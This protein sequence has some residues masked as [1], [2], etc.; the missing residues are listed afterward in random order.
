MRQRA[1][2]VAAHVRNPYDAPPLVGPAG[3]EGFRSQYGTLMLRGLRNASSNWLGKVIMAAVVGFLV[4]SF[5]IWGIGDIFRGFGRSTFAK[6]GHT[7]VAIEQFR[8]LYNERIQQYGRQIGRPLTLDQARALGLDRQII[9]QLVSEIALDERARALRLSVS[10]AEIARR[11]TADPSFQGV[12]GQFDRQRF[13]QL[14]RQGGYTEARYVAE[15][16]RQMVR[17]QLAGSIIGD[18]ILPKAA[19]EAADRYHNEQRS[20][21]YV[22][23]DRAKA[24]EVAPPAPEVLAKYFEER[25]IL[26]RAPEYRKI[27]L[28]PLVPSEL[29]QTIEISDEDAKGA[30]EQRRARYGTPEQRHIQQLV[31]SNADDARA[32]ADRFAKGATFAQITADPAYA[33]KYIDLGLMAKT[34]L[35]DRA[36]ADA[37]FGLKVG[38]VSEPVQGRFGTVLVYVDKVEPEKTRSFEEVAAELKQDLAVE[39][40]RAKVS[41]LYNKIEDERSIG[42][43]LAETAEN[44]KLASRTIEVDRSGR[45]PSGTPVKDVPDS[46]RLL[47]AAFAA[48]PGVEND[49]LQVAGGYVWYDVS[50]LT[51]ARERTLDEVKEQVQARWHD[52]EVAS[53]LKN[54]TNEMLDKLKIGTALADV[55]KAEGLKVETKSGLKRASG[56]AAPLS[57]RAVETVFRTAKD[58]TATAEAMQPGAQVIFRVTEV[59]VPTTDLASGQAKQI[60]ETLNRSLLQDI[61]GEYLAQLED[62]IGVTINPS[63]L[64]QIVTGT[65][66]PTD[67]DN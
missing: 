7:E 59:V 24:G 42:K 66:T 57:A 29:A 44:L 33:D 38:E 54:K 10:D 47:P 12:N 45:D 46:Q 65:N 56:D 9:G 60:Q 13:E 18:T 53:R 41:D 32:V 28:L 67:D 4:I 31:F 11:I 27:V 62:E 52:D 23:I 51:P 37:A 64:R 55:A 17:R 40:A 22:L 19:V 48:D 49:P 36:V 1:A 5:A 14:I 6:I 26:F 16:R 63:A 43:T 2:S 25:K 50:G 58:A 15:Q 8:Q 20:I 21:D 3:A 35:I 34:A 61:Y 30:Y 39:R